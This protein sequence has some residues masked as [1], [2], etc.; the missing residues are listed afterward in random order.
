[1]LENQEKTIINDDIEE[2]DEENDNDVESN[3]RRNS[4][5]FSR[6]MPSYSK[7]K[8]SFFHTIHMNTKLNL[9]LSSKKEKDNLI[10]DS[11]D[12][13]SPSYDKS[14]YEK[15]LRCGTIIDSD[16]MIDS[17]TKD[18]KIAKSV[19]GDD[20]DKLNISIF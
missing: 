13:E 12:E 5:D 10:K 15:T 3:Y 1:M 8:K 4:Q 14:D 6:N 16:N 20:I 17:S 2:I 18:K 19:N 9:N 11:N 7:M